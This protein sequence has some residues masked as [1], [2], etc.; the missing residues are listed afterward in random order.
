MSG[1]GLIALLPL[2]GICLHARAAQETEALIVQVESE[3]AEADKVKAL[4]QVGC[5]A[6]LQAP[7]CIVCADGLRC[8]SL[9]H[10][11]FLLRWMCLW[12]LASLRTAAEC[13]LTWI[14]L[15]QR[16]SPAP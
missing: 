10:C 14:Y 4:V 7:L 15:P 8:C 16:L 13:S 6:L 11:A 2:G 5:A 1:C 12:A 9:R 3:T